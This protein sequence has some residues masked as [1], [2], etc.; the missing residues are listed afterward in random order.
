[1]RLGT[2]A[3]KAKPVTKAVVDDDVDEATAVVTDQSE[4]DSGKE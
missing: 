1:L 4:G 3:R 2:K